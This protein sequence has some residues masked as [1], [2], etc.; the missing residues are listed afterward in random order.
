MIVI[1]LIFKKKIY[2]MIAGI[3]GMYWA[4]AGVFTAGTALVAYVRRNRN[5]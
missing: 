3:D 1:I 5:A 4:A 2:T